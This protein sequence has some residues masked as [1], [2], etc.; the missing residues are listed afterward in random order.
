MRIRYRAY[1]VHMAVL[2]LGL[3]VSA[4]TDAGDAS[5]AA[6]YRKRLHVLTGEPPEPAATDDAAARLDS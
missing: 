6:S 2:S 4:A 1:V 5:Q 3:L